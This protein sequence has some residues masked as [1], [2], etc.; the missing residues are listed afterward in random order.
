MA[1]CEQ[2]QPA[3]HDPAQCANRQRPMINKGCQCQCA[4]PDFDPAPYWSA[5]ATGDQQQEPK[6]DA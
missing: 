4:R 2:C 1:V 3:D 5:I 6:Q